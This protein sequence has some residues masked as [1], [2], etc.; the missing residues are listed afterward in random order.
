LMDDGTTQAVYNP[1]FT[2]MYEDDLV[3]PIFS[4][5]IERGTSDP[6]GYLAIGGLPQVPY[7][8]IFA[9]API[10]V[11]TTSFFNSSK[12]APEYQFYTIVLDAITYTGSASKNYQVA[13]WTPFPIPSTK[14]QFSVIIDTGTTLN[15]F[16]TQIAQAINALFDPPGVYSDIYEA[17]LVNCNAK[18]PTIGVQISGQ[19]FYIDPVDMILTGPG[20]NT[21]ISGVDDGG[22]A[23]SS[24][25]YVLGDVFLKN[26]IAVFDIGAA[27]M[28]FASRNFQVTS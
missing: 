20:G 4:I 9:S 5:A 13:H 15:Y 6:A 26:V 8:P 7:I 2:N 16:P 28:R 18:A 1:I 12:V 10:S 27:E 17:Y 22:S 23:D 14:N 21:C 24:S 11:I 25:V 3:P 19:I